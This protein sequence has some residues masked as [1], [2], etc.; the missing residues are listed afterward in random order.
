VYNYRPAVDLHPPVPHGCPL[1][2]GGAAE[3]KPYLPTVPKPELDY[4]KVAVLMLSLIAARCDTRQTWDVCQNPRVRAHLTKEKMLGLCGT[5]HQSLRETAD[6]KPP[7]SCAKDWHKSHILVTLALHGLVKAAT[8]RGVDFFGRAEYIPM[9]FIPFF[10]YKCLIY[11]KEAVFCAGDPPHLE[12]HLVEHNRT[13]VR[14][15]KWCSLFCTH[16]PGVLGGHHAP[17]HQ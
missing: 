17:P 15:Q 16:C 7:V 14:F 10:P 11:S 8:L 2:V 12:K 6:K 1:I 13:G 9:M 5:V 3:W 4:D